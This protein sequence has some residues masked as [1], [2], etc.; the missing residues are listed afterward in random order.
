MN[1]AWAL[2]FWGQW[3]FFEA[4]YPGEAINGRLMFTIAM[5]L[6]GGWV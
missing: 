1:V 3:E 4:I 2:L 5:T 6:L